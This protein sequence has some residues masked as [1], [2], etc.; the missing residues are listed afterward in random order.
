MN[1]S[2]GFCKRLLVMNKIIT[3]LVTFLYC[4]YH[5]SAVAENSGQQDYFPDLATQV[6]QQEERNRLNSLANMT[7]TAGKA[8]QNNT[9]KLGLSDSTEQWLINQLSHRFTHQMALQG[10]NILQN[11]G[12]PNFSLKS[13][14]SHHFIGSAGSF[15]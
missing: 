14:I 11:Y 5:A 15:F 8:I 2:F 10:E 12:Q 4:L 7:L 13:D 3:L 1:Y 6:A 9:E